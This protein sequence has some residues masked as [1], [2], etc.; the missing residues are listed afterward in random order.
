MAVRGR[1]EL[2]NC[3]ASVEHA[4][5]RPELALVRKGVGQHH[6]AKAEVE[7][8]HVGE[9]GSKSTQHSAEGSKQPAQ[10]VAHKA[11]QR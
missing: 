1:T 5:P 8:T 11:R 3:L 7:V 9:G 6:L 10:A 2:G 4:Q